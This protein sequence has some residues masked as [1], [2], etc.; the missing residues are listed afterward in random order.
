MTEGKSPIFEHSTF[1]NS[2]QIPLEGEESAFG[3]HGAAPAPVAMADS[4]GQAFL[5]TGKLQPSEIED[6]IKLQKQAKIRFGEAAIRLGYLSE[7]DVNR[8]LAKQFNY[9]TASNTSFPKRRISSR[10]QI[11]HHPYS[12]EAESIRRFRSEI[13]VRLGE[14]RTIVLALV[15]PLPKEGKSYIAASLAIAFAQLNIKTLLIDANLRTPSLH[16]YFGLQNKSGLSTV[17]AGRSQLDNKLLQQV[18]DN[19]QV[20]TSGP[21]PPNPTEILSSPVLTELLEHFSQDMQVIILDTPATLRGADAQ[22]VAQQAGRAILVGRKDVSRVSQ[23]RR[24]LS[25][26]ASASVQVLGTFYN[27]HDDSA[28]IHRKPAGWMPAQPSWWQRL[29]LAVGLG[30]KG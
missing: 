27:G 17:L 16:Q 14:Q 10:L 24:A 4:M 18:M 22:V 29:R 19:L 6:V 12:T 1:Q 20:L 25:E 13:L 28:D 15:S 11:A 7:D 2:T 3:E 9:Q 23:L 26:M 21:K 5:E 30:P 8:V